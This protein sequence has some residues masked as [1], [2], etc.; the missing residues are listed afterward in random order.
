MLSPNVL[1]PVK[2]RKVHSLERLPGVLIPYELARLFTMIFD[3]NK[4]L[5]GYGKV[6]VLT[7]LLK[8]LI[9]LS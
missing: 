5:L 4:R 3:V 7:S 2:E 6:Y 1:K 8:V 9:L